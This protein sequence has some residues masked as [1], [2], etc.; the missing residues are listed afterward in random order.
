M[1]KKLNQNQVF[2]A[3]TFVL[4]SLVMVQFQ[5]CAPSGDDN[6][7]AD[8]NLKIVDRWHSVGPQFIAHTMYVNSDVDTVYIDGLCDSDIDYQIIKVNGDG[9]E[10]LLGSG[11]ASCASGK[12]TVA[13]NSTGQHLQNCEDLLEIEARSADSSASDTS[14]VRKQCF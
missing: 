1:K 6:V 12:F 10:E 3:L 13:M 4:L 9:S 2:P 14:E 11:H 7:F 5:N 8:T